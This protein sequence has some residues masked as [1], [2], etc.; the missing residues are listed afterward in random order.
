MWG[1]RVVW[2]RSA[3]ARDEQ[4]LTSDPQ[5]ARGEH[6]SEHHQAPPCAALAGTSP[7]GRGHPLGFRPD[8]CLALA[9]QVRADRSGD[10]PES[11][12]DAAQGSGPEGDLAPGAVRPWA[13]DTRAAQQARTGARKQQRGGGHCPH[14]PGCLARGCFPSPKAPE[15]ARSCRGVRPR[16]DDPE[17][18]AFPSRV[19]RVAAER[20]HAGA[21]ASVA[22][23]WLAPPDAARRT[24]PLV[25]ASQLAAVLAASV[26]PERPARGSSR[27]QDGLA[28]GA[29]G[30][31][32]ERW[33]C[34][35]VDNHRA[36][37][38]R[39]AR[40]TAVG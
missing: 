12:G 3:T 22:P 17:A 18:L 28:T 40:S 34:T 30:R 9:P 15:T 16:V 7:R 29:S 21:G 20:Q 8:P 5:A 1:R 31:A 36:W 14:R 39:T 27:V 25:A 23:S 33:R 10:A 19:V 35:P 2:G 38:L 26:F 13:P 4:V 6:T 37:L 11:R 32:L 24:P